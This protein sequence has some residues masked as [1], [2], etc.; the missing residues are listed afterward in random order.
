MLDLVSSLDAPLQ[1][2]GSRSA[3]SSGIRYIGSK[4]RLLRFIEQKIM[5]VI[6]ADDVIF[7]DLFA[8]TAAVSKLFKAHGKQVIESDNLRCCY[9]FAHAL[10]GKHVEL[11]FTT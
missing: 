4:E 7:G 11:S 2:L 8:G 6:S 10:L 9:M 3:P 1:S 5:S